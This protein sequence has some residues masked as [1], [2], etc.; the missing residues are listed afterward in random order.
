LSTDRRAWLTRARRR[1]RWRPRNQLQ[2]WLQA[3]CSGLILIVIALATDREAL[4]VAIIGAVIG[5]L[6]L[7]FTESYRLQRQADARTV[8][9]WLSRGS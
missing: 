4:V 6:T 9:E 3:A 1:A 5:T 2:A 7:G 8:S